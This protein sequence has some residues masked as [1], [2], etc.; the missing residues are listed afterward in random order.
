VKRKSSITNVKNLFRPPLI[1]NKPKSNANGIAKYGMYLSIK[2]LKVDCEPF[3][4]ITDKSGNT[5][6]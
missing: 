2:V 3:E 5:K 4:S 1:H 6:R